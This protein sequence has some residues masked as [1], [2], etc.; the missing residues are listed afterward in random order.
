[1]TDAQVPAEKKTCQCSLR[2]QLLGDG[3]EICNPTQAL[4]YA[5]ER[6]SELT[7]E[8]TDLRASLAREENARKVLADENKRLTALVGQLQRQV[9]F[10]N[11][12]RGARP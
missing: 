2:G 11:D 3:C 5:N 12:N 7:A 8:L 10:M 1:M 9:E 4:E 6:I